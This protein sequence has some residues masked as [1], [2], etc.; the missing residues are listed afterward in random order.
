MKCGD[1]ILASLAPAGSA[2]SWFG[3]DRLPG[4]CTSCFTPGFNMGALSALKAGTE[5]RCWVPLR[6]A[7]LEHVC[8]VDRSGISFL[9]RNYKYCGPLDLER[10]AGLCRGG[11]V[12][13]KEIAERLRDVHDEWD[14]LARGST[15]AAQ[16]LRYH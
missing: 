6:V 2:V 9:G 1:E 14:W 13:H 12:R 7:W 3:I 8:F 4:A 15:E 5:L 11:R 10:V 16:R